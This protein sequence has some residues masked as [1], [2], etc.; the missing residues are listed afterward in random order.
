MDTLL[1]YLPQAVVL[2]LIVG[3]FLFF[4]YTRTGTELGF[5]VLI[6]VIAFAIPTAI[7]AGVSLAVMDLLYPQGVAVG[8]FVDL[9]WM[10]VLASVVSMVVFDLGVE[11]LLLR[12]LQKLG[13][14]MN[15]IRVVEEI[16]ASLFIALAL[17]LVSALMPEAELSVGVVLV[18]GLICG[19]VRYMIGLYMREDLAK[20]TK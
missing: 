13:M 7:V 10:V 12:A 3:T 4:N 9:L 6:A 20:E 14:G 8:G 19:L 15:D 18:A 16:A 11:G 2:L 5:F 1:E 17:F